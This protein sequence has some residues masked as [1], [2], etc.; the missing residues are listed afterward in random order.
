[1]HA[2][3]VTFPRHLQASV[4]RTQEVCEWNCVVVQSAAKQLLRVRVRVRVSV[5][6]VIGTRR[7]PTYG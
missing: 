1:M 4:A 3:P 6:A 2:M 7:Q 5:C